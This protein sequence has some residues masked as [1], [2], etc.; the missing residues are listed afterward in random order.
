[1][2]KNER[3]AGR[4]KKEFKEKRLHRKSLYLSEDEL[5]IYQILETS[6]KLHKQGTIQA[7]LRKSLILGVQHFHPEAYRDGLAQN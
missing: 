6:L 3:G 4:K 7:Y 1:M 2:T 5:R